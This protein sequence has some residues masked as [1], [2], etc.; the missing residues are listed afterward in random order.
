[1]TRATI[2]IKRKNGIYDQLWY[3]NSSGHP[4]LLG[5][6]IFNNL[7]TA[8]DVERAVPIFK[9]R[10]CYSEL[11]TSFTLGEVES[12]KPILAQHNDYSYIIDEET[13][14]WGFYRYREEQWNNL[15]EH[16]ELK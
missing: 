13:G 4:H 10:K 9:K 6:E 3:V 12:I 7:K 5:N 2:S 14:K 11:E 1:M 16:I 8:D 15:E